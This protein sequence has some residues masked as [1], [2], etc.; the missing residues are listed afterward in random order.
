MKLCLYALTGFGNTILGKALKMSGINDTIVLTRSEP[1]EF[2]YYQCEDL[3]GFCRRNGITVFDSDKLDESQQYEL[4]AQFSPDLM[5]V[6]TYHKKIPENIL[7]IP[8]YKAI[9]IHPSLLPAYRGPTPT[10]WAIINGEKK[11][12]ITFHFLTPKI[13]LGRYTFSERISSFSFD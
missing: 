2:P 12:G 6:A 11:T 8:V 5:V 9:N 10:N 3:L 1:A 7:A 13:R 4:I